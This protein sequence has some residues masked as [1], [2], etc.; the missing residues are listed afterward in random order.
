MAP[1]NSHMTGEITFNTRALDQTKDK[2][3]L[4]DK[5]TKTDM[6]DLQKCKEEKLS[7]Y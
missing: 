7:E 3:K 6:R 1:P 2:D 5:L 4:I